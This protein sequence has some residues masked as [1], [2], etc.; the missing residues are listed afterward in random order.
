MALRISK[1]KIGN[2]FFFFD[3]ILLDDPQFV[4]PNGSS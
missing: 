3:K 4:E 2:E 1:F